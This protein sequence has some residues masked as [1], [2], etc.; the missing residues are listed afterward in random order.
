[1]RKKVT[2]SGVIEIKDMSIV[3]VK[4][5]DAKVSLEERREK[6]IDP[7]NGERIYNLTKTLKKLKSHNDLDM[8]LSTFFRY[9]YSFFSACF[10]GGWSHI[11]RPHVIDFH[12]VRLC[13]QVLLEREKCDENQQAKPLGHVVSNPIM[14][15]KTN[16]L[17][18]IIQLS[19]CSSSVMGGECIMMLTEKVKR[20]DIVVIFY[21]EDAQKKLIWKKELDYINSK[22]KVHH[23]YTMVFNTPAYR[24]YDIVEPRRTF[25]QIF[26]PSDQEC[27]ESVPFTF[28]PNEQSM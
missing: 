13:F 22:I 2:K 16:G 25:L 9:F 15:R 10:E 14:N 17:L 19:S 18:K 4:R 7:T 6:K 28:V 21:E 3:A 24:D 26:R 1:M 23:Q 8:K 11:N 20:E 5:Q 27:S 12:S